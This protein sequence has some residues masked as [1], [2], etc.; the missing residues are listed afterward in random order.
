MLRRK[1]FEFGPEVVVAEVSR[2]PNSSL[3]F[4]VHLQ[5]Q[6]LHFSQRKRIASVFNL[7]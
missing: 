4:S 7:G 2:S 3:P 6:R 1:A 5:R